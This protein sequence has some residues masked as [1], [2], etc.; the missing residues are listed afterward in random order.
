[1]TKIK[2][3]A[4]LQRYMWDLAP[5]KSKTTQQYEQQ[6]E[7]YLSILDKGLSK[8]NS[9]K[10][11]AVIGAGMSGLLSA[12]LLAKAGHQVTIYEAN[13]IVGGR[14]KTIRKPF[15]NDQIGEAGA[16]RLPD[17]YH[18]VL[19]LIKQLRLK[20]HKFYNQSDKKRGKSAYIVV[21][22]VKVRR[23]EYLQNPDVFNW[24]MAESEKGKT[25]ETLWKLAIQPITNLATKGP[26]GW[27]KAI[28]NYGHYSVH[29]Y[30]K[31]EAKYS[32]GA[33]EFI[34]V[35]LNL[36]SRAN[37]SLIQQVIE[38]I[39]HKPKTTYYGITGGMDLLPNALVQKLE[40]Y[41]VPI[42]LNHRLSKI[43]Q[44]N[45]GVSLYFRGI[46]AQKLPPHPVGKAWPTP[47]A[48]SIQ[49]DAVILTIPFPAM[50]YLDIQ[51]AFSHNKRKVIRELNYDAATKVF[52]QFKERF[53]ETRDHIYG[54]HTITD[55]ANR[56]IYYPS[57]DFGSSKGGVVISSYTWAREA[58]GWDSL[59][60]EERIQNSLDVVAKIHGD[61]VR[62]LFVVGV[63]QSWLVDNFSFGEAAMF[64]PSQIQELKEYI[65]T[66]EGHIY[67]AGD[68]TSLKIAWIEGAIESAIRVAQEVNEQKV[69]VS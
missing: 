24:P 8:T 60:E 47:G 28:E 21:N 29:E 35:L 65:S 54:G 46:N 7:Q 3:E 16:M 23:D 64:A 58:K 6:I 32:E 50:R 67:F 36:E 59:T 66:P 22:G 17:T 45:N 31:Q 56:F 11:V 33:I 41:Q 40:K 37:L 5:E 14:I 44:A 26:Q 57:T 1:M 61:Y 53:W 52:L 62:D 55:L 12:L 10:N 20:T 38:E 63:S 19:S 2:P 27:L 34:E 69:L 42:L 68:A 48:S 15:E 39:N 13:T 30:L 43:E 9:P 25:A 49:A 4:N 51:P 18:L